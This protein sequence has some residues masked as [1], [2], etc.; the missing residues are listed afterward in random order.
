M[1]GK[2]LEEVAQTDEEE[3]DEVE[4][5][6]EEVA[7]TDEEEEDEVEVE[8]GDV[9][10]VGLNE[11]DTVAHTAVLAAARSGDRSLSGHVPFNP[12]RLGAFG[13]TPLIMVCTQGTLSDVQALL[14][15][16]ADPALEGWEWR[17][18]DQSEERHGARV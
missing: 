8:D 2:E 14:D 1:M 9:L 15:A 3:E 5:E 13:S 17:L 7:Q 6:L 12:N 18:A 10:K 16:N 11:G 4:K